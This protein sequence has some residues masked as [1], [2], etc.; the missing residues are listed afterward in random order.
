MPVAVERPLCLAPGVLRRV[1]PATLCA[2]LA[3]WGLATGCPQDIGTPLGGPD[4]GGGGADA[5]QP[6]G[7][8]DREDARVEVDSGADAG[9][10]GLDAERP[11]ALPPPD[12][13]G[14]LPPLT[15]GEMTL[16]SNTGTVLSLWGRSEDE[17]Y[18][19]TFNGNLLSF[20]RS[21]GWSVVWHEPN[22]FAIHAISGTA[23]RIFVASETTLHVHE[24]GIQA[25]PSRS[26]PIG[27]W[28]Y[29]IH[30][31]SDTEVYVTSDQ[32]NGRG[33]YKYD[34]QR[35]IDLAEPSTISTLA[36]VYVD[37]SSGELFVGGNGAMFRYDVAT[38]IPETVEWLPGW[39]QSEILAFTFRT[40]EAVGGELFAAGDRGL[41]FQRGGD[42]VWRGVFLPLVADG[43]IHVIRGFDRGPDTE[44]Y[45]VAEDSTQG[46]LLRYHQGQWEAGLMPDRLSLFGL[47]ASGPDEYFAGGAVA[48]TFDGVILRG[49]R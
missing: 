15:W 49:A 20:S 1:C 18:A 29:A 28:I 34:G 13:G 23:T 40:I 41:V 37:P 16:P 42:G 3:S 22:N 14:P 8:T 4:A 47:W 46:P 12:A 35:I 26:L 7:G 43:D 6:D 48:N 32:Q 39:G 19:G 9:P 36:G 21:S 44:A 25:T 30:V 45:A 17:I 31:V 33:V 24:G 11:D 5:L 27:K 2:L 38:L 10:G